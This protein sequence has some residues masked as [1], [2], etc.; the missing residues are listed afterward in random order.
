MRNSAA[1]IATFFVWNS[2]LPIIQNRKDIAISIMVLTKR[3]IKKIIILSCLNYN[4]NAYT[5]SFM[6]VMYK[7]DNIIIL[8]GMIKLGDY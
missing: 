8:M 2:G 5:I 3:V 4:Q 6:I 1:S 7:E